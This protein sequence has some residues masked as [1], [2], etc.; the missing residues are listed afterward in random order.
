MDET[1][2]VVRCAIYTRKS[3]Q[4][5]WS[6]SL[7]LQAQ[8]EAAEAYIQSQNRTAGTRAR[9]S[10]VMLLA[11]LAPSI[12]E[13]LLFLPNTRSGPDCLTER[14]LRHIARQVDWEAQNR[15]FRSVVGRLRLSTIKL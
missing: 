3:T 14:Q 15:L 12:Q 10:Q 1:A 6:R 13:A 2:P 5:G 11:N 8:R 9:L 7:T 4:E